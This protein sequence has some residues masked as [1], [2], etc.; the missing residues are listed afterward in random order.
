M[1]PRTIQISDRVVEYRESFKNAAAKA[2]YERLI[3]E[4]VL[5]TPQDK[6]EF[7]TM[8]PVYPG[9]RRSQLPRGKYYKKDPSKR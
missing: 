4:G 2:R 9:V 1:N 8:I 7:M 5:I 6:T 3:A